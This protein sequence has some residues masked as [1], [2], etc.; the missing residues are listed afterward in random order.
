M[1]TDIVLELETVTKTFGRVRA[2]DSVTEHIARGE[3]FCILGPSGCGKTTLL[4]IIAGFEQPDAGRVR[5]HGADVTAA[6]P[7]HRDVNVVFQN[8]ALFPHLDTFAN[9]A[10]GLRMKKLPAAVVA[11]RTGE[12]VELMNLE[13]EARRLPRQLSGGQQQRVALAR[14]LVNRPAVLVL[15]EPLSAL[16][17]SLRGRMQAELR[18]I[19]RETGIAFVHITHD[20]NEALSLAD[21][22]GVMRAGRFEQ[23]AQPR[24]IYLQPA[25]PFVAAFVG[26]NNL[27]PARLR[28]DSSAQL[29]GGALLRVA[30]DIRA[31]STVLLAIRPHC[32]RVSRDP[33]T[34]RGHVVRSAFTG[35]TVEL[36]LRLDNGRCITAAVAAA[37][38]ACAPEGAAIGID[39]DA[40][41]ILVLPDP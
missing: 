17:Q 27:L 38:A 4:R 12:A 37:D 6:P 25:N 23:V 29:D 18:R 9:I 8:Y 2:V 10:F 11:Q 40:D 32:I 13:H 1:Q 26:P 34:L 19:Q 41:D 21:R 36:E 20:Q 7:E 31:D 22:I 35:T 39:I 24:A 30:T 5:L 28:G 33:G 15:D 16:D 3:Y 14:A